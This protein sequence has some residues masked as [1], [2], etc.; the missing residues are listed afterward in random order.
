MNLQIPG[1]IILNSLAGSHAYGLNT[2]ESDDDYRGVFVADK[3]LFYASNYP[4]EVSDESNDQS[5][6]EL[7]KF[8][9]LLSKNN[10]TVLEF[11]G[12]SNRFIKEEHPLFSLFKPQDFLT[13][14]CQNS[15][16]GYALGQI[17]KAYGLKKR[18]I[19]PK[20]D[21][22]KGP[23]DFCAVMSDGKLFPF[24]ESDIH[25]KGYSITDVDPLN[26]TYAIWKGNSSDKMSMNDDNEFI[27]KKKGVYF[28]GYL[29]FDRAGYLKYQKESK[30][31]FLWKRDRESKGLISEQGEYDGKF[32]MHTFRLL[33]TAK[34]IATK[35]ELIIERPERDYLMSIRRH[36]FQFGEL[37]KK[38]ED[39]VEE[40]RTLFQ[41]C[42]L[43]DQVDAALVDEIVFQIRDQVYS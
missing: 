25:V 41:K 13:K 15:Y 33:Y 32:L 35:G 19:F 16:V 10:P 42:D 36:E 5:F 11:L 6:F 26:D 28:M 1:K 14:Q 34:D 38:A 31:Y 20:N 7:S 43:P 21:H 3:H 24:V 23:F 29:L 8:A 12:Y 30:S 9:Q 17:R 27:Y 4:L 18:I 2:P 39:L 22:Q 40:V 37:I